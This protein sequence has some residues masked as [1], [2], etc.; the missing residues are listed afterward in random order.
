MKLYSENSDSQVPALRFLQKLGWT[1]LSPENSEVERNSLLSNVLLEKIL[2][3]QLRK[4][5]SFDYKGSSYAFSEGN[6]HAAIHTIK[7]VTDEGLV[8]TSEKIYDLITLGKSFE[9]TIQGD[10]KSFTMKYID[11][12]HPANNVYHVTEEFVVEGTNVK[13]R[14]DLVLFVNG[15]P[16]V[17]IENKRRDKDNSIDESISQ[18]IRNQKKED[19]VPRLFHYAQILL[20][21]QPNEVKYATTDTSMDFWAYWKEEDDVEKQVQSILSQPFNSMP[22]EKRLPT[23]QD[24]AL[25]SFC[26]LERIM[27]LVYKFIVY[28]APEKKLARYQQYFAVKHSINRIHE[29]TAEGSRKGGVIWHTQGSGKSLTMVML[30]KSIAL[31]Q[32]IPNA[33]IVI[34]SDRIE[35]D[36]QIHKTFFN[37]GK[38]PERAR[39]GNH[40]VELIS[41]SGAE[42]ITTVIDKFDA[43]LNRKDFKNTSRNIFVLVDESHRSQYGLTHAKMKRVLPNACYIGFT[44][45]P[46]FKNDKSTADKFG[47]FIDK[48]TI[49]QAVKDKAVVPLLYEGR[50]AKLSVNQEQMN[51]AFD[52]LAEPLAPTQQ[53]DLKRK[54]SSISEIYKSQWVIDEIAYDISDHYTKNWKGTGFKAMLAVPLKATALKYQAYFENQTNPR[55]K[56][57]SA[58]V[59]SSSDTRENHEDTEEEPND[60]V[61]KFVKKQNSRYG[62]LE[63]YDEAIISKFKSDDSE[64]ELLIV[65]GKLLTG[66]DAPRCNVLYIAKPLAEHN[67]LQAIARVNRLFRGKDFG[68]IIDYIGILGELDQALTRYSALEE[69]DELDLM[70]TVI[71]IAEELKK[72]SQ[73]NSDVWDVFK[74][75]EDKSDIEA[76]ERFLAPKD[77]RDKFREKL[78]VFA[79]ALQAGMSSDEFYR[80]YNEYRINKFIVDLKFFQSLRT[81]VQIRYAERID[82]KEYEDRVRKLLDTYISTEGVEQVTES[83]NIF[84]EELFKKEVERI[85]GTTA[86]KADAIAYKMKKVITEKMEEDPV[87][88]KRF[89]QLIDEA[90]QAFLNRRMTEGEY[91]EAMMSARRDLVQGRVDDTPVMLNGKPEAR[92]LYGI[93][94]SVLL[95]DSAL[96]NDPEVNKQIAHAGLELTGIVQRMIIRDWKRNEDVQKQMKNELEDYLLQHRHSWGVEI[97][98]DQVD[99]ILE[100]VLKVAKNVF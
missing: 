6:I 20:A 68:Y 36:K 12:E 79:K 66:F 3:T 85:T 70:G 7:N 46:L 24:K 82:Y 69:F 1:H 44:G 45:T 47:G 86:S 90:I 58:V 34:V 22:V 92:A 54:H 10:R 37:C 64:V 23:E 91:L 73:F 14:I 48:Y 65:V 96:V 5:N 95:T 87:F 100:E 63:K 32:L 49:N 42:V 30:A 40:L 61:Q 15:I 8:R 67:L 17:V 76:L 26:R 78:I 99:V 4:I 35:L 13:R 25:L 43:A 81:S 83:V 51:R 18:M 41:E 53:K 57:N 16:F 2:E 11:W 77:I 52:R 93:V 80:L 38:L 31:D 72:I 84:D 98:Y 56:I 33:R 71:N 21:M 97:T 88:Y 9:E 19:G 75:L 60:E 89:G 27:E 74:E 39:S 94:K 50:A 55:L 59:I 29:I 28:D 62:S